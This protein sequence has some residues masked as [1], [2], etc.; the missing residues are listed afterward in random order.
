MTKEN[1]FLFGLITEKEQFWNTFGGYYSS[2]Y[3]AIDM[4][5]IITGQKVQWHNVSEQ[6]V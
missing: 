2:E 3:E 1:V 6:P 4:I 5:E